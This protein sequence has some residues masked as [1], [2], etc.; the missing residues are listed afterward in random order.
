VIWLASALI[1]G[2]SAGVQVQADLACPA[3]EVVAAQLALERHGGFVRIAL[4]RADGTLLADRFLDAA[5][6]CDDLAAAAAAVIA[7]AQVGRGTESIRA[8]PPAAEVAAEPVRLQLGVGAGASLAAGEVGPALL[9]SGA[10]QGR[11]LGAR[12]TFI[13]GSTREEAIG[14]ARLQWRRLPLVLGPQLRWQPGPLT[15]ETHLGAA[16]ALTRLAGEG[17]RSNRRH[18]DLEFGGAAGLR[19]AWARGGWSPWLELLGSFWPT[20][21][22]GFE[23]TGGT[24]ARPARVEGLLVLGVTP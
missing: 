9:L 12:A 3:P 16:G 20:P 23:E 7:S 11:R 21:A 17:F 2:Q 18:T 4:L 22:V 6:P 8:L 5:Q 10:L 24:S 15:I 13:A 14:A 1:L 19:L